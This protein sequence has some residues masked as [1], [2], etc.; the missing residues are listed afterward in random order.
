MEIICHYYPGY[1]SV[2]KQF[3]VR[4]GKKKPVLS[5]S[6]PVSQEEMEKMKKD[7]DVLKPFENPKNLPVY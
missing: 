5:K 6:V 1:G 3:Q 7:P 2:E 4:Y